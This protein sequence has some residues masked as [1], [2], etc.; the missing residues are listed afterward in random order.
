MCGSD[1]G[2]SVFESFVDI[3]AQTLSGGVVG[4]KSDGGGFGAS[5]ITT[6]GLKEVTGAKAAEEANEMAR[7]QAEEAKAQ[8]LKD[9][10]DAKNLNAADQ[11]AKSRKA[12]TVR[13]TATSR[14]S[15]SVGRSS[16]NNLGGEE[17]DF[18][19]L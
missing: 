18:L 13:S 7:E 8:I 19:G 5:G 3:A 11:L 15:S 10:E 1:S 16:I 9:R 12:S 2:N 17:R 14:S 4:Y 6:K